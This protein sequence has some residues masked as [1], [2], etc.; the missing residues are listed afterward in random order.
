MP[1]ILLSA[2]LPQGAPEASAFLH[3]PFEITD[4]EARHPPVAGRRA[5]ARRRSTGASPVEALGNWVA[6][7]LQGPLAAAREQLQRLE[8]APAADRAARWRRWARS[9]APWSP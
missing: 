1:V 6:Q 7:T 3:K 4:F 5:E 9:C 2:V 8:A